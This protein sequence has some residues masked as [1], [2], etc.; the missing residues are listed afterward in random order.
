MV[1]NVKSKPISKIICCLILVIWGLTI[2]FPLFW[3]AYESLK[4]NV[5]FFQDVW[6]L[7]SILQWSNYQNA[8]TSLGIGSSLLNTLYVVGIS[9]VLSVIITTFEA[10][11]FTRVEWKGRKIIWNLLMLS[12]FLPGINV[13]VPDYVILRTLHLTNSLNGLIAFYVVGQSV[14]D[15]MILGS[16]MSSIPKEMEESATMDGASIWKIVKDIIAPLSMP[17]IVTITIFKF[18]AYYNDFLIPLICLSDPVNYTIGVAMYQG[19]QLMQYRADWVTLLAGMVIT[20]IPC[21]ILYV[22]FQKRIV[23]G[24]SL[25]AIKG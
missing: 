25:G 23:E 9:M 6:K 12:L 3:I 18:I 24:A 21:I 7:P 5:E 2:L 4:T 20:I 19:N 17:G 11:A 10:Y 14:V 1:I 16:F 13:L 22:I 8:W 15:L